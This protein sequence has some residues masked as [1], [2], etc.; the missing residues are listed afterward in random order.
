MRAQ[1]LFDAGARD[2]IESAVRAAE[3]RTS[4][5]I[6]PVVVD[7]SHDYAGVR[8]AAR[9]ATAAKGN[10]VSMSAEI[11]DRL[12]ESFDREDLLAAIRRVMSEASHA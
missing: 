4:G 2:A 3:R 11:V 8:A 5:E 10:G 9:V 7:R 1:D 6:V 12:R